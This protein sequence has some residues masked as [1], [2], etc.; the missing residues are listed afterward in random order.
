[1]C[2]HNF[3]SSINL[4]FILN[5]IT[6]KKIIVWIYTRYRFSLAICLTRDNFQNYNPLVGYITDKKCYI[7]IL[8]K[9]LKDY[10]V[11]VH[12]DEIKSIFKDSIFY[13]GKPI[14]IGF[15]SRLPVNKIKKNLKS[16]LDIEFNLFNLHGKNTSSKYDKNS[17]NFLSMEIL[18]RSIEEDWINKYKIL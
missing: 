13:N 1:M 11:G 17:M 18:N 8:H 10:G 5:S 14:F 9:I 4:K 2:S 15:I 3:C 7:L 16:T 12:I 6:S